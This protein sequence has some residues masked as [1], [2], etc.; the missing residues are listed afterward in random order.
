MCPW[1]RM[2]DALSVSRDGRSIVQNEG[3]QQTYLCYMPVICVNGII[4]RICP[5]PGIFRHKR[6]VFGHFSAIFPNAVFADTPHCPRPSA[7]Q[8]HENAARFARGKP[9]HTRV[10]RRGCRAPGCYPAAARTPLGH[11]AHALPG[12]APARISGFL[13]PGQPQGS[14]DCNLTPGYVFRRP[15]VAPG[16]GIGAP[17]IRAVFLSQNVMLKLL[18][19]NQLRKHDFWVKKS[20]EEAR[21]SPMFRPPFDS[22]AA[23]KNRAVRGIKDRKQLVL[24]QDLF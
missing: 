24:G 7:F 4:G 2:L 20:L 13:R 6:P 21:L 14:A 10:W 5:F 17:A 9:G 23:G 3:G 12:S 1:L 11:A 18:P 19:H 22:W 15:R 16:R 8:F